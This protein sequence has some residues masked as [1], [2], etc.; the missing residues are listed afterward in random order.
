MYRFTRDILVEGVMHKD[1]EVVREDDVPKGCIV[2]MLG[3]GYLVPHKEE[4]PKPK[5]KATRKP[6]SGE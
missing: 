4:K 2:S 1:G 6:K 5:P 3:V